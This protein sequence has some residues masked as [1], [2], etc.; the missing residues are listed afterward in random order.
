ML[1]VQGTAGLVYKYGF[2]P[3][4]DG[5]KLDAMLATAK[6]NSGSSVILLIL[7]NSAFGVWEFGTHVSAAFRGALSNIVLGI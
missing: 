1:A 7:I 5:Q 3:K 4:A 6:K 2:I